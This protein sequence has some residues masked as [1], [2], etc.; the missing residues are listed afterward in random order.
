MIK[1]MLRVILGFAIACLAAG[2][3]IVLFV[4]TPLELATERAGERVSEASLFALAAATHSAHVRSALC[5]DRRRLRRVAADRQLALLR[6]GRHRHCRRRLPGAILGRGRGR[7]QHRQQLRG[8][9]FHRH[10][11]CRRHGLLAVLGPQCVRDTTG[12]GARPRR[13]F[14]PRGRRRRRAGPRG[15][16]RGQPGARQ[17]SATGADPG[18]DALVRPRATPRRG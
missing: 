8:D 12:R 5:V 7:R 2:F 14:L 6:A 13:S 9:G 17:R 1:G 18:E 10:G 3:T 15:L 4:Y 16:P 11:I